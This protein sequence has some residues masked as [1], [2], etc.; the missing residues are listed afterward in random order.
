M[1]KIKFGLAFIALILALTG[2]ATEKKDTVIKVGASV[3]PQDR[4]SV[5]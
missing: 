1:K 4:K 3:T 2:C 5:V